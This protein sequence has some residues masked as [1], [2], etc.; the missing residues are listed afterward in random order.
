MNDEPDGRVHSEMSGSASDLVQAR[1]VHGGI[2]FHRGHP[3]SPVPR[4]LPW[5]Q[6]VFVNRDAELAALDALLSDESPGLG[7]IVGMAGVGKTSLALRWSQRNRDRFPD[8]QLYANLHGY[9]QDL[10][11][12]PA[13]VLERFL[14]ALG[15]PRGMVPNDTDEAAALY[16]SAVADRRMLILLDNAAE[17]DQVRPLLPGPG[18]CAVLVT[19]R[20][21]MSGLVARDGARRI[22]LNVLSEPDAVDLLESVTRAERPADAPAW[23]AELARLCARLPIALRVAAEHSLRRPWMSLETL[24][25]ELR[26]ESALW[27]RLTV[28]EG[29]AGEMS[30]ARSVFAWSY[31]ALPERAARL[32]RILSSHPGPDFAG[33]AAAALAGMDMSLLALDVLVGAHLLEQRAPDRYQ[34]HDLVRSYA[35]DQARQEEEPGN[36]RN[37]TRR[38][39]T[40]YMR[41][42]DAAQ[43][44]I[45]PNEAHVVI[46]AGDDDPAPAAFGSYD[47]AVRWFERERGNL[48]AAVRSAERQ[49]MHEITW[50]LAVVLRGLY[51][52]FNPFDDWIATSQAGLRAAEALG[53]RSAS[54]E[55]LESLGMVRTQLH[56]LDHGA[57]DLRRALELRRQAADRPGAALTL[58]SLGLVLLRRHHLDEA[59]MAFEECLGIYDELGD[60]HWPPVIRV[61]LAEILIALTRYQQA[62]ELLGGSLKTFRERGDTRGEGNALRLLSM[63]RRGLGDT[64]GAL[65]AAR[66]AVEIATAH[67]NAILEGYWLLEL[68]TAQDAAGQHDEALASFERS[69][70]LQ[71]GIGDKV[72]EAQAWDGSG[73]VRLELGQAAEAVDLHHRAAEVF[74]GNGA[75]WPLAGALRN[76]ALARH[77]LGDTGQ[78][79]EAAAEAVRVLAEFPD[80][81]ADAMRAELR[82]LS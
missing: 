55:L 44:W 5:S 13:T 29:G 62:V 49:S 51:M 23:I 78:A 54:A 35:M 6:G 45:N 82:G 57:D 41:S 66:R 37:A 70:F 65:R 53:D 33:A 48:V 74:R 46:E 22:V 42:A 81:Q 19:S 31:R 26:G 52:E 9:D 68:G 15:V 36:L 59:R 3:A 4:Q 21:R 77:A 58:N 67:R 56:Q 69:A 38:V 39:L 40:W 43:T 11:V 16:R 27:R 14:L 2:H 1:D 30:A 20:D 63:A 73:I 61:N 60:G 64:D 7:V 32:F 24:T 8:G 76:L 79:R 50:K 25:A 28:E 72:R 12:S 47:E 71:H 34:F 75:S 80:P 18:E 17:A 10:P